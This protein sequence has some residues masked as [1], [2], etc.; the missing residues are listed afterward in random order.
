MRL[1]LNV[2]IA[3]T[4]PVI[5]DIL[6][7]PKNIKAKAE[8]VRTD[9]EDGIQKAAFRFINMPESD[10]DVISQICI[11]KQLEYKRKTAL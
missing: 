10:V 4:E 6:F 2:K 3:P 7:S 8:Y 9:T 11:K 5:I 1:E